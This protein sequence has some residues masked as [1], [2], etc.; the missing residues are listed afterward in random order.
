[1]S[2]SVEQILRN[3]YMEGTYGTHVSMTTPLGKFYLSNKTQE[4]FWDVY[5][6]RINKNPDTPVGVAE[7]AQNEIPVIVDIDLKIK[8][9][10]TIDYGEHLYTNEQ[11]AQV[12]EVYQSVLRNVVDECADTHLTCVVLEKPLYYFSV[13][14]TTYAKNGFHLHFPSCFL[15]RQDMAVHVIPRVQKVLKEI[16]V[17]KDLGIE[18]SG[19]VVDDAVC[20]NAWLLYGSRKTE[21]DDPYSVSKIVGIDG[22]EMELEEAFAGYKLFDYLEYPIKVEGKVEEYLPRI[23]SIFPAGRTIM[24]VKEGLACPLKEKLRVKEK[25]NASKHTTDIT[26]KEALRISERLLQM[27]ADFRAEKYEEWMQI[28]WILYNIG[29]GSTEALDQ[30]ISFSARCDE[31]FDETTCVYQWNKMVEKDLTL[32]TLRYFA[33]LDSP[34]DYEK[35]KSETVQHHTKESLN[36]SHNDIAKALHAQFCEEF[37]CASIPGRIWYQF[38]K[39]KWEEIEE[40]VDLRKRIS[41]TIVKHFMA[42]SREVTK[43]INEVTDK[44]E[45]AMYGVRIKQINK[46]LGNL[47]SA[48][49]KNNVMR[50]AMEEFY[51]RRFKE[52]L[53]Q[54]PYLIGFKNGVY[55]L[56]NNVF[57]CGCPEDFI[58]KCLPIDYIEYEESSQHVQD[59]IEFLQKVFP[60]KSVRTYFLDTYSD[61]F[62]GGNSQKKVY[63]WTGEGDNG[64]SITQ[65]LIEMMLG[66]HAIKMNTQYFTSKKIASGAANPE[67]ARAAPPVRMATMDEPDG[68]E[69]LNTGELKK[70]SGGDKYWARD[71]F[72]K[73]KNTREVTPMFTITL[74]CNG[75]PKLKHSDK[76]T[77]NR[78]RVLPFEST[79]IEPGQPCPITFEEQLHQKRFPMDRTF[80]SK[81]PDMVG[82]FAW[83]LL[84]WRKKV[85]VRIEPEKVKEATALYRRQNDLYRQFIE[86]CIVD[87]DA[88]ITLQELYSYFKDWF[89]DGWPHMTLPIKNQVKE[90]F[91]RLWGEPGRGCRWRGY[92]IRTLEEE[93]ASGD[94][95]IMSP[96]DL[97][98][99]DK[100]PIVNVPVAHEVREETIN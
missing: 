59:I 38:R 81:L 8:D 95:V 85:T 46:L 77:W 25:N 41:D 60:D 26:V 82:A 5:S 61:I 33:K 83:Y 56:K 27:L 62:V 4:E 49:Y 18:D 23:L 44:A 19:S 12:I 11:L 29:K 34:E 98:H 80:S 71:L 9:E 51:D 57:R 72:E 74:I 64:K 32:G 10:G 96:D 93:V 75:L 73:G 66:D 24:E 14:E 30:W 16:E 43:K 65:N 87:A 50:E 99:Y 84:E 100:K 42:M 2:A 91:D 53:D 92:R 47:K 17:F 7:R 28:G 36:G 1:M 86:E 94:V 78:L 35:F 45:E 22:I 70:L 37:V 20:R 52:K 3:N 31:K 55:D 48:P 69:Q 76:A 88:T 97:I 90:Y 79:F 39:H 68:D 13:G 15:S 40:G 54:N 89:K 6:E 58:S 63:I 21:E 67:L